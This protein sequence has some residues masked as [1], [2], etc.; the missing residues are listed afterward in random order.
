MDI[1]MFHLY[2]EGIN[3]QGGGQTIKEL[4]GNKQLGR[5]VDNQRTQYKILKRRGKACI[6]AE[7]IERLE[8]MG[9]DWRAS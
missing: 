4:S 9:F 3:N 1:A 5:W 2:T 7:R 6:T 8:K